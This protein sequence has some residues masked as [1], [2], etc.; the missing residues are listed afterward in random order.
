MKIYFDA[1]REECEVYAIQFTTDSNVPYKKNVVFYVTYD[2]G[3]GLLAA[4]LTDSKIIDP[5]IGNDFKILYSEELSVTLILWDYFK[6]LTHFGTIVEYDIDPD[7][8][9]DFDRAAIAREKKIGIDISKR[10]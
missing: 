2:G 4:D 5:H 1:I 3:S 9:A 6:D 10:S 8:V 7:I